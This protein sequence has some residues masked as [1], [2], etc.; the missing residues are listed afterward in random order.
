MNDVFS[1]NRFGLL[2]KASAVNKYR[3][4]LITS[5]AL[6]GVIFIASLFSSDHGQSFYVTLSIEILFIF[7]ILMSAGSFKELHDKTLNQAYLLLP[8]S[9]LEKTLAQLFIVTVGFILYLLVFI[10]LTAVM[11]E[12]INFLLFGEEI[13]LFNPFNRGLW[14][15]IPGYLF[16]QSLFFLGAAWFKKLHL[17]KTILAIS[18]TAIG[19]ALIAA[20]N[21]WFFLEPYSKHDLKTTLTPVLLPIFEANQHWLQWSFTLL[22]IA[23]TI[24]CWTIA[25]QRVKEAQVSDGI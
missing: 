22:L 11:V 1:L 15:A 24:A 18:L 23:I 10:S 16:L 5:A 25:W 17:V 8:A 13:S 12:V 9:S 3:T 14:T 4:W 19:L 20:V 7:G 6:A 21:S 2:L